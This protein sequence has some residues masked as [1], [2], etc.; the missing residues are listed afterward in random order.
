MRRLARRVLRRLPRRL[1]APARAALI[2][3]KRGVVRFGSLR[4]LTPIADNWGLDRGQPVDRYYIERF[5]A[6]HAD[7]ITGTV[8]EVQ[9]PGYVERFGRDVEQIEVLDIDPTNPE[10]TLI[11]DLRIPE[12]LPA[13]R[14]DCVIVTQ[15]LQFID[16][17]DL[18][19]RNLWQSLAPGGTLL[20]TMPTVSKLEETLAE[21]ECWR[22]TPH[23]LEEVL[24]RN[25]PGGEVEVEGYGN[26]LVSTSFLYGLVT[27]ELRQ[28]EL[29]HYDPIFPT[30][31]CGCVTKP[32]G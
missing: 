28:R 26:I 3:I 31:A 21:V 16:D 14:F 32:A 6:R 19:V 22:V 13:E 7:R 23:G 25:C 27:E 4:R 11:A 9:N 8:L 17:L 5:I 18:G 15:T 2:R 10:A 1:Q 20:V 30:G 12:A 29:D 24:R